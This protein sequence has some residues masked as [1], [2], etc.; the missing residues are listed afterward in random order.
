MENLVIAV[1]GFVATA[2][3]LVM[4]MFLYAIKPH[5]FGGLHPK[6][7]KRLLEI[8]RDLKARGELDWDASLTQVLD[9]QG[10]TNA[11]PAQV[12]DSQRL[13]KLISTDNVY[14]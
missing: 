1:W 6:E 13:T 7:Q 10:L 4:Y 14:Y 5:W 11:R 3:P 2:G 12:V 8:Y 9:N